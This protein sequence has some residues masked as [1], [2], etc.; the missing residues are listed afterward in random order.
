L[1]PN[2]AQN[3]VTVEYNSNTE[4]SVQLSVYNASGKQVL[5]KIE[6]AVKGNNIYQLNVAHYTNGTYTLRL[7]NNNG[8]QKHIRFNILK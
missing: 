4:S 3:F 2:P 6:Y 7:S 5:N 8:E 1:F